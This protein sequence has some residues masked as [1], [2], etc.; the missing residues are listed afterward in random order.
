ML[1]QILSLL[2]T[3]IYEM[4]IMTD[5]FCNVDGMA[6][7]HGTPRLKMGTTVSH[8]H[9]GVSLGR[10]GIVQPEL[11]LTPQRYTGLQMLITS[12]SVS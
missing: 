6:C 10:Q 8:V 12:Q 9:P 3:V 2:K 1:V 7:W 4:K 11:H 5:V